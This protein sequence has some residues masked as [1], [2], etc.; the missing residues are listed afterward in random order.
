VSPF[1]V[2]VEH[3][4]AMLISYL[5]SLVLWHTFALTHHP[6]VEDF[7]VVRLPSQISLKPVDFF[8][9]S[10]SID[11]PPSSQAFNQSHLVTGN[12]SCCKE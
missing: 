4:H 8:N 12:G 11:V 7:P 6:R 10:P 9:I 2:S 3:C 5:Y 1:S